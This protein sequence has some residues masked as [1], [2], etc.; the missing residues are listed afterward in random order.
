MCE[1]LTADAENQQSD[2]SIKL[3][4]RTEGVS[5]SIRSNRLVGQR[6][7]HCATTSHGKCLEYICAWKRASTSHRR[8]DARW[9]P[10]YFPRAARVHGC[11]K[12]VP[13]SDTTLTL[14]REHR[15][16]FVRRMPSHSTVV[17]C[18]NDEFQG[19]YVF[20]TGLHSILK[21]FRFQFGTWSRKRCAQALLCERPN[22]RY[23]P[24][25]LKFSDIANYTRRITCLVYCSPVHQHRLC[26]NITM[27]TTTASA[28][29]L[30]VRFYS[31]FMHRTP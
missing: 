16:L 30:A 12:P 24:V 17:Q 19:Q 9:W 10:F 11:R 13:Q 15:K 1:L 27:P 20:T 29:F 4:H 22:E 31:H 2:I 5:L 6:F 3:S 26:D 18:L 8:R 28:H 25:D 23:E 21:I 7:N 14:P